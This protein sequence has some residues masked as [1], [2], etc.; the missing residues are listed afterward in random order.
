MYYF[1]AEKGSYSGFHCPSPQI[2]PRGLQR[3]GQAVSS[4][5]VFSFSLLFADP[6]PPPLSSIDGGLPC[7][8]THQAHFQSGILLRCFHF[9][10]WIR[11]CSSCMPLPLH[12]VVAQRLERAPSPLPTPPSSCSFLSQHSSLFEMLFFFS[13]F[14]F[15]NFLQARNR[16]MYLL[17]LYARCIVQCLLGSWSS[18]H[19][20]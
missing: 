10:A 2:F 3:P 11:V 18:V 9:P 15:L 14:F 7:P 13:F 4:L 5:L 1:A 12:Q 6:S 17:A 8:Q 20:C 16:R 19:G